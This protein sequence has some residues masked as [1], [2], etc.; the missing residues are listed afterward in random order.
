MWQVWVVKRSFRDRKSWASI[1]SKLSLRDIKSH[2]ISV[3]LAAEMTLLHVQ[4]RRGIFL[5]S[6]EA[7]D[8][9]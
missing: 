5:T 2:A 3:Q 8:S 4:W 9:Q 7:L 1:S 6:Q